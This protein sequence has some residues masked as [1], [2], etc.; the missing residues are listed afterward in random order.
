MANE[1]SALPQLLAGLPDEAD[2]DALHAALMASERGRHFL[3]EYADRNRNADT[4]MVVAAIARVEAALRGEGAPRA[5]AIGDL[6]EVAAALDR[7]EAALAI[8][9]AMAPDPAAAIERLQDIAFMLHE[10]PVEAT[11]C[12]G[13]DAA[14]RDIADAGARADATA[15]ALRKAAEL[16]QALVSRVRGMIGGQTAAAPSTPAAGF[17]AAAANDGDTV[18]DAIAALTASLPALAETPTPAPEASAEPAEALPPLPSGEG[19]QPAP[20]DSAPIENAVVA[21]AEPEPVVLQTAAPDDAAAEQSAPADVSLSAAVL[22]E[23]ADDIF[24][25]TN[26]PSEPVRDESPPSPASHGEP[27]PEAHQPERTSNGEPVSELALPAADPVAE[28]QEDPDDLFEPQAVPT[29][30]AAP[31]DQT[32]AAAPAELSAEP[33]PEPEP[34]RVVPQPPM[35]AIARP[36]GSDPLAAVRDLSE[37]ELIAL[38][39]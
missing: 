1:T 6:L 20:A 3:K 19:A 37:E 32:A 38:F 10:R 39:S 18:V 8:G 7:I 21:A 29:A 12:D 36:P 5:E 9:A 33:A 26:L 35:R 15:D 30:D 28:L 31:V 11:L 23:L 34:P 2:Y 13:L 27:A 25:N 14:I 4:A 16:L 22:S 17:F 24:A